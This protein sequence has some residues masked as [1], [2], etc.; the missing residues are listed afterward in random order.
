MLQR[1]A[2][3]YTP[4]NTELR[5]KELETETEQLRK[6]LTQVQ[7]ELK[8]A[9]DRLQQKEKE[10]EEKNKKN[11]E[12]LKKYIQDI[13]R[14]RK[15]LHK[16]ATKVKQLEKKSEHAPAIASE[17]PEASRQGNRLECTNLSSLEKEDLHPKPTK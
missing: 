2:I 4:D 14:L 16:C 3:V 17:E 15:S 13:D 9:N 11:V 7:S 5:G 6:K 12:L 1:V 8:R 10:H